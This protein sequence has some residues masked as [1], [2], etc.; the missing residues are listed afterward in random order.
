MAIL[1]AYDILCDRQTIKATEYTRYYKDL[2]AESDWGASFWRKYLL[3]QSFGN[4]TL[5]GTLQVALIGVNDIKTMSD[6]FVIA[7]TEEIKQTDIY[8]GCKIFLQV[9][10]IAKKYKYITAK[11]IVGGSMLSE[12]DDEESEGDLCTPPPYFQSLE[13]EDNTFTVAFVQTMDS[14]VKY[15]YANEDKETI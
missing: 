1:D 2:V 3:V 9:P 15:P 6:E 14:G 11:F 5:G 13:P 12:A 7:R 10:E 8:E 4:F